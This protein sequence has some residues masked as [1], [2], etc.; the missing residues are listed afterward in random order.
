MSIY[1]ERA[2]TDA[3][4]QI[5]SPLLLEGVVD[6]KLRQIRPDRHAR[7][8]SFTPAIV[9]P[10]MPSKTAP[11][12]GTTDTSR[13]PPIAVSGIPGVNQFVVATS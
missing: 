11:G 3:N 6:I 5:N 8:R 1:R 4:S 10:I 13:L 9:N 7:L 12:T 2:Y